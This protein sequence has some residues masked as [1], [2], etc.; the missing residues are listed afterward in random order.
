MSAGRLLGCWRML[1]WTRQDVATGAVPDVMGPSPA[2]YIASQTIGRMRATVFG[3]DRAAHARG[4]GH[5][6]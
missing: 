5:P 6:S 3:R 2:G 1:S 4:D